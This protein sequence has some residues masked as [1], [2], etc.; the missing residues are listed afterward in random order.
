MWQSKRQRVQVHSSMNTTSKASN[1]FEAFFGIHELP[2]R[3]LSSLKAWKLHWHSP[4][5]NIGI[6]IL[7]YNFKPTS[8]RAQQ[9]N[10]ENVTLLQDHTIQPVTLYWSLFPST[11]VDF[12]LYRQ[13]VEYFFKSSLESVNIQTKI[14][15]A[16]L[17]FI[18]L[19]FT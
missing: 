14:I 19:I 8:W 7:K 16:F 3:I 6:N 13:P 5:T 18:L 1:V 9:D 11:S 15:I 4:A 10:T 12:Y 17:Y 2:P